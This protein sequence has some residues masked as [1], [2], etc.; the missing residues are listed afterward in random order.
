MATK[1]WFKWNGTRS[2]AKNIILNSA[3]SIIKPEERV[4]HV[5]IP[6]RSGELTITEGDQ[7]Y[8]SYIQNVPIAVNG[9]AN[10]PSVENWLKGEGQVIFSTQ[11]GRQQ[12]ARVIGAVTLEKHS[13]HLDWWE[14]DVQFYCDPVKTDPAEENIE[15]TSSGATVNNPGD[16]AALPLITVIGSGAVT[17]S[18][19]GN[20]LTIPELTSGWKIDSENEWIL[21]GTTPLG[22]VC[23]GAFPKLVAGSN[24]IAFTG[25]I[26]KLVITPR[27]RYL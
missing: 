14:G 22:G 1:Y 9:A 24:T 15:V 11:S 7:V 2:D 13:R 3:P 21:D 4:Q 6:G 19:G 12:K 8:Q 23:S 16:M 10:V 26:T 25:S 5:T 17:I 20:V 27:F 18:A